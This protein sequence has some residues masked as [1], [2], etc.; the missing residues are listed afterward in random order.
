M[1]LPNSEWAAEH[2]YE[3][4]RIAVTSAFCVSDER[5]LGAKSSKWLRLLAVGVG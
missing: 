5:L 2:N 4:P 1:S 3:S